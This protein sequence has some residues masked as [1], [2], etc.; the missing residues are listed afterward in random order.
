MRNC[1]VALVTLGCVWGCGDNSKECGPGTVDVEGE[2]LPAGNCG[3]GT[4]RDETTGACVP[5]GDVVCSEGTVFDPLTGRCEIDPAS[6]R[7]GTV[8]INNACVDPTAGLTIDVE[9][10][11]EPNGLGVI[12]A[13]EAQAGNIALRPVNSAFVVHG[14]IDP[15]RDADSDG[16]LDPDVDTYVLTVAGPVLL[17]VTADGVHGITAGFVAW[18]DVPLGDPLALWNRYGLRLVGD[19]SQRQLYLPKAGTYR[20]AIGDTRSL[21]EYLTTPNVDTAPGS[22]D[23]DYYVSITD[24]GAPS[25][26]T[27]S[28]NSVSDAFD[29]NALHFYQ[30]APGTGISQATVAMPST[31]VQAAVIVMVNGMLRGLADET[32]QPARVMT[33]TLVSGDTTFVVVDHVFDISTSSSTYTLS[34]NTTNL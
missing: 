21:V 12:E 6:C 15:W 20:I 13:S 22:D 3:F 14:K 2:C 11:P 31:L 26:T 9:E 18:A 17:Q 23:G 29:G 4:V 33:G 34:V 7:D 10:G 24:L 16:M 30:S 28:T 32:S 5:N 1:L 25:I 27:L 8:L 19:A